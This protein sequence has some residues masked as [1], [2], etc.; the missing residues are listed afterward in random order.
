MPSYRVNMPQRNNRRVP[1]WLPEVAQLRRLFLVLAVAG[2]AYGTR[3]DPRDLA[4]KAQ[5][6]FQKGAFDQAVDNWEKA[7]TSF[8]KQGNTKAEIVTSISLASA[9][10]SLGDHQHAVQLLQTA[11]QRAQ[12]TSDHSSVLLLKSKLGAAL[13]MTLD[14][15]RAGSLLRESLEQARAEQDPKLSDAILNDLGNLLTDK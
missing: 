9:Y 8:H 13:L 7:V 3:A 1:P 4:D 14:L 10:Q 5:Q 12:K 11:L 15:E 2:L 6:A